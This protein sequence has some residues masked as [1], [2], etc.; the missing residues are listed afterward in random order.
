M[1]FDEIDNDQRFCLLVGANSVKQ[2]GR[3]AHSYQ[4]LAIH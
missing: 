4:G 3:V 2:A 1:L